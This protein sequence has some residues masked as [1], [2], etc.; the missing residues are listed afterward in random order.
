MSADP[1]GAPGAS[2]APLGQHPQGG[3]YRVGRGQTLPHERVGCD[4]SVSFDPGGGV[5]IWGLLL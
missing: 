3:S 1:I 5:E 2:P 4:R